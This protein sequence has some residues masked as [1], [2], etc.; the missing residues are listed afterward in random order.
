MTEKRLGF[1]EQRQLDNK[2]EKYLPTIM[3]MAAGNPELKDLD[4]D[5]MRANWLHLSNEMQYRT[6]LIAQLDKYF[7][8]TKNRTHPQ[9][10]AIIRADAMAKNDFRFTRFIQ[11]SNKWCDE[12]V[13]SGD[14]EAKHYISQNGATDVERDL[15][16]SHIDQII[17]R[18][19]GQIVLVQYGT[20]YGNVAD[21]I[22]ATTKRYGSPNFIAF[23]PM[24][25]PGGDQKDFDQETFNEVF[26]NTIY[27]ENLFTFN[28]DLLS[29]FITPDS[30]ASNT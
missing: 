11:N 27:D 29:T 13:D 19:D 8:V 5:T 20:R 22:R 18:N 17:K 1:H 23:M 30:N 2:F 7:K 25:E 6:L 9:E 3:E 21:K 4:V 16:E 28:E 15:D 26:L 24:R 12:L 14:I 10:Q